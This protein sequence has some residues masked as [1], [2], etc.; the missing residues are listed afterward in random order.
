MITSKRRACPSPERAS[1]Y[2]TLL[3]VLADRSPTGPSLGQSPG[4][5]R[6][7]GSREVGAMKFRTGAGEPKDHG[8]RMVGG[9]KFPARVTPGQ[10]TTSAI[11]SRSPARS[12]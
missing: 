3:D 6:Q 9:A 10:R 1:P 7:E 8:D 11:S 12:M 4:L 5:S 2:Q